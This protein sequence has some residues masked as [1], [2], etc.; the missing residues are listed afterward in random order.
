MGTGKVVEWHVREER[1]EEG[2]GVEV[3]VI[4]MGRDAEREKFV[5]IFHFDPKNVCFNTTSMPA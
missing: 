4:W 1:G 3:F 2:E 5:F